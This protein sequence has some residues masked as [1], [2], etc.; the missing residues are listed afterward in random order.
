M[1]HIFTQGDTYLI[2]MGKK[3]DF[4]PAKGSVKYVVD[5][6]NPDVIFRGFESSGVR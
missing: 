5:D 2:G 6:T 3:Y 4:R 1:F